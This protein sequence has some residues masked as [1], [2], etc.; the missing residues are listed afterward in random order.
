LSHILVLC[1][2]RSKT[3]RPVALIALLPEISNE[4]FAERGLTTLRARGHALAR[5][6]SAVAFP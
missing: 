6:L 2:V 3:S 1:I 4:R 5:S